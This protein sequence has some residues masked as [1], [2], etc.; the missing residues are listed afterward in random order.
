MNGRVIDRILSSRG[1]QGIILAPPYRG[2]RALNI[3]W[4]RYACVGVGHSWEPQ[5]LDRVANDHAENVVLAFNE[6][7]R[8]GYRRVGMSLDGMAAV[9]GNGLKWLSGFLQMQDRLPSARCVPLFIHGGDSDA[10]QKFERWF[11]RCKPDVL[12]GLTGREKSFLDALHIRVPED[13]GVAC[14]VRPQNSLLAGI[15][16]KN[17]II[18][19][20]AVELVAAHIARNEFGVPGHPKLTLIDGRWVPGSS[21]VPRPITHRDELS[22]GCPPER[23]ARKSRA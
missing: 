21:V 1:I 3:H 20:A 2:N 18:G 6:L 9:G 19:A 22:K 10:L 15:D 23:T 14:L 7:A 11:Q 13:V 8:L 12:L 17:E 5:Q 4:E 16:E